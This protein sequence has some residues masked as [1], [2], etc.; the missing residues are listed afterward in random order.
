MIGISG[1][2]IWSKTLMELILNPYGEFRWSPESPVTQIHSPHLLVSAPGIISDL[3]RFVQMLKREWDAESNS[4]LPHLSSLV[5][6]QSRFLR[7]LWKT[8]FWAELHPWCLSLQWRTCPW[9]EHW[10]YIKFR[11]SPVIRPHTARYTLFMGQYPAVFNRKYRC[12][13]RCLLYIQAGDEH[14]CKLS[15][16]E[17]YFRLNIEG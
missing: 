14:W 3:L 17:F 11:Q 6:L 15:G 10:W 9:T 2:L 8:C 4:K 12:S 7:L 16:K 13:L 5:K 1:S